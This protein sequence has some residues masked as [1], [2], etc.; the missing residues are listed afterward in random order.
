MEHE[1][2]PELAIYSARYA[3]PPPRPRP[4][5]PAPAHHTQTHHFHDFRA[6][7]PAASGPV[8][9]PPRGPMLHM[10]GGQP[11]SG[12]LSLPQ[13][14]GYWRPS[15]RRHH[16]HHHTFPPYPPLLPPPPPRRLHF[17]PHAHTSLPHL[18]L[19]EPPPPPPAGRWDEDPC[20]LRPNSPDMPCP[21]KPRGAPATQEDGTCFVVMGSRDPPHLPRPFA[22]MN[23]LLVRQQHQEQY[24]KQQQLQDQQRWHRQQQEEEGVYSYAGEGIFSPAD[25]IRAQAAMDD[26]DSYGGSLASE[27]IYEEIPDNWRGSWSRR[28]L[29]EE[30]MDEYERVR[31]GHRRVLSALNLDVETLIR[32]GGQ[33]GTASPDS[34]LTISASDSSCEPNAGN[35]GHSRPRSPPTHEDSGLGLSTKG[36]S[37]LRGS[38]NSGDNSPKSKG[39]LVKCE[40]MDF[41]EVFSRRPSG[42]RGRAL[43]EK[44]GS[45]REKM[46]KRWKFPNFSK[47]GQSMRAEEAET[48]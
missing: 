34:G 46:E 6:P 44:I 27:N 19:R 22:A 2:G 38:K 21:H 26:C 24:R 4:S 43:R 40:S 41:K 8:S 31:A 35:Y 23:P 3:T 14:S 48:L 9:L 47:K 30:V 16:H 25:V 18:G 37:S 39:R 36:N 12:P 45:V 13:G 32:P 29:V 11:F 17:H 33:D 15:P 28:S 42:G 7:L 20:F 5:H 1:P 10:A